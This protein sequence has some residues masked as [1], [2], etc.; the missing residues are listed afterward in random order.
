MSYIYNNKIQYQDSASND[1]FGRLRMSNIHTLFDS[2]QISHQQNLFYDFASSGGTTTYHIERSSSY[3]TVTGGTGSYAIRQ[4]KQRFNYQTGKS[5]LVLLTG[6]FSTEIN[7]IKRVGFFDSNFIAPYLPLNGMY[8][9]NNSGELSFNIVNVGIITSIPQSEW[10]IDKL[11][12]TGITKYTLDISKSH[13]IVMDAEWLGVGRVRVGF[14]IDGITY[15]VHHFLNANNIV[16]VYTQYMNLP[17]RYEIRSNGGNGEMEQICSTVASEGGVEQTGVYHTIERQTGLSINTGI[18]RP[19]I[20][21][22]TKSIST[23]CSVILENIS[24]LAISKTDFYYSLKIY[25]GS[26]TVN[27][28][29]SPVAWETIPFVEMGHSFAEYKNDFNETYT[30]NTTEHNGVTIIGGFVSNVTS[31]LM[32][33]V[34]NSLLMG[35]KING[36]RDVIVLEA[37]SLTSNDTLYGSLTWREL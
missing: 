20:A 16:G 5:Q 4:T 2:K 35:T 14:N 1:A 31:S 11:D 23:M 37:K 30:V 18:Y 10:N 28:N 13:I 19:I 22:R 36:E 33:Q 7:V 27:V 3:L 17:V 29:A 21:I 24:L 12:G 8:F 32:S 9:E 26:E 25:S 15:Y 34:R 6:V